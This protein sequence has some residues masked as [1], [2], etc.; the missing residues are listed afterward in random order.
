[1]YNN[2]GHKTKPKKANPKDVIEPIVVKKSP[3][4]NLET[5][6]DKVDKAREEINDTNA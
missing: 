4:H 3:N 6:N 2:N 5:G 1:M